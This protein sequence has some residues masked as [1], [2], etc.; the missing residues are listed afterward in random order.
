MK[1]KTIVTKDHNQSGD[2][3]LLAEQHDE[4]VNE[5]ITKITLHSISKTKV[6]YIDTIELFTTIRYVQPPQT[7]DIKRKTKQ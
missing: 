1:I 6:T 7:S 2:I 4:K 5:F 3:E